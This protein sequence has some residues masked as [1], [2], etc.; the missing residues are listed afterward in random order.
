MCS[1]LRDVCGFASLI[2]PVVLFFSWL[3]GDNAGLYAF[4]LGCAFV[5]YL[6]TGPAAKEELEDRALAKRAKEHNNFIPNYLSIVESDHILDEVLEEW[7]GGRAPTFWEKL[8]ELPDLDELA[9]EYIEIAAF[10]TKYT[11]YARNKSEMPKLKPLIAQEKWDTFIAQN[12][13]RIAQL[14]N[15]GLENDKFSSFYS[16][17]KSAH[18]QKLANEKQVAFA[19]QTAIAAQQ[20]AIAA[21][22]ATIA[23]QRSASSAHAGAKDAARA[24]RHQRWG[25]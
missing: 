17:A 24:L 8:F 11:K 10:V 14:Q 6:A 1:Y 18:E 21:Q 19:Q 25:W 15:S 22:Q 23:A 13:E 9:N 3:F 16:A 5:I 20:T 12:R 4:A 2:L 7:E